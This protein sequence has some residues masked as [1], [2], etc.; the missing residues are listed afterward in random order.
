MK[1]MKYT[2]TSGYITAVLPQKYWHMIAYQEG[3][4]NGLHSKLD[5]CLQFYIGGPRLVDGLKSRTYAVAV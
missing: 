3:A 1:V 5:L 4:C 2:R